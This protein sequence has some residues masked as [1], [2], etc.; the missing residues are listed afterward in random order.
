MKPS[1]RKAGTLIEVTRQDEQITRAEANE[2]VSAFHPIAHFHGQGFTLH[3]LDDMENFA[4]Y[5]LSVPEPQGS[6]DPQY[7]IWRITEYRYM[8]YSELLDVYRRALTGA[9]DTVLDV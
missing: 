1:H 6:S 5:A 8:E 4:V 7:Y 2:L 3:V 9:I